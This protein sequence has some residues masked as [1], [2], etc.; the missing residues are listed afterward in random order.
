MLILR[1]RHEFWSAILGLHKLGAV[2][3][4]ATH[5]LTVKDIVYRNNAADIRMIVSVNDPE[6]MAG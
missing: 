5:L 1:R 3:I 4:P 6:I 2:A